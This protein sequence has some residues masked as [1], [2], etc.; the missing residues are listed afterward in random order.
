MTKTATV[1][2]NADGSFSIPFATGSLKA[3]TTYLITY[4]V[5]ADTDCT[6]ATGTGSLADL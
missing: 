6:A 2:L 3:G 5:T 1:T 4:S